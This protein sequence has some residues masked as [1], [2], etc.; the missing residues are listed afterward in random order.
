VH[1]AKGLEFP[2]VI[3]CDPTCRATRDE[4]SRHV[5]PARGLWAE[6]IAG[7][8]PIELRE[9]QELE[10]RHDR[11]EAVRLAYVAATRARDLLVVPAIGDPHE[12]AGNGWLDVLRPA[13]EP[14]RETRRRAELA[15]GCPPFGP[16][17]VLERPDAARL[18]AGASV[19]PGSHRPEQ[20]LHRVVWWDPRALGLDVE[21]T[22]GLRQQKILEADERGVASEAGV[23]AHAAW[24]A[25]LHEKRARGGVAS[26]SVRTV[27]ELAETGAVPGDAAIEIDAAGE[28]PADRPGG[29]RFGVLVHAM[30]ASVA[31]DAADTDSL[32]AL[33]RQQGRIAGATEA[34][35]A[36]AATAVA[37]AL[38]HPLLRRAAAASA[39]GELRRETPVWLALEDGTLAEGVVDLAFREDGAWT[40]VDFKTDRELASARAVYEAQVRL[41]ARAIAAAT[42]EPV[43]GVLLRV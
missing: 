28:A 15:R 39:R 16:D 24:Q 21:P 38:A 11:E 36:A 10:G 13:I 17:S 34:E 23:R 4:A 42:G 41:Y 3:L 8:Q 18:G 22:V 2:V 30:L 35:I 6:A 37:A 12:S 5:D 20:G 19:A 43:C 7:C 27:T 31:L 33:A 9:A 40:V 25:S 1:R 14:P 26:V 32:A 29:R